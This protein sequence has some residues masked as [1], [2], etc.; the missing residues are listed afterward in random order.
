[1]IEQ[2]IATSLEALNAMVESENTVAEF[3]LLCSERFT[4]H[5]RFWAALAREELAHAQ[6]IRRLIELVSIQPSE[7]AIGKSAPVD[8]IQSFI[9]RTQSSIETLKQADLPEDKALLMA[10]QIENTFIELQYGN[11]VTTENADYKALLGQVISDTLRHKERV[12][13]RMGKMRKGAKLPKK[14]S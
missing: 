2:P 9:R 5:H 7:F 8:A 10:Y 12:V 13:T 1:M 3:Y 6:V 11:V 4:V 14:S